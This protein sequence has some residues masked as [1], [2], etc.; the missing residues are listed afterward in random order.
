LGAEELAALRGRTSLT[1][2]PPGADEPIPCRVHTISSEHDPSTLK[3]RVELEIEADVLRRVIGECSGGLEVELELNVPDRSGGVL[4][5]VSFISRRYE[6][7]FVRCSDGRDLP[8]T[9]LRDLGDRALLLLPVGTAAD[10]TL[11]LP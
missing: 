11:V 4:V 5:P 10:T 3:R 1:V 7:S 8:V 6:Q 2:R 9:V